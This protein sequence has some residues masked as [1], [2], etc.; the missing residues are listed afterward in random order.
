MPYLPVASIY[1]RYPAQTVGERH[2]GDR[3]DRLVQIVLGERAAH[4]F[5]VEFS[6]VLVWY[7]DTSVA[8]GTI[9]EVEIHPF[10]HVVCCGVNGARR[11][12]GRT[13]NSKFWSTLSSLPSTYA[14][15]EGY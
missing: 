5:F 11:P 14:K 1:R 8:D 7:D 6:K 2:I 15:A 4:L 9:A 3:V 12:P 10:V 13:E